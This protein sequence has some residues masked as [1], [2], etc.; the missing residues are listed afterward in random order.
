MLESRH[1]SNEDAF[2][3]KAT[4]CIFCISGLQSVYAMHSLFLL[5]F[6]QFKMDAELGK[7]QDKNKKNNTTLIPPKNVKGASSCLCMEAARTRGCFCDVKD[8]RANGMSCLTRALWSYHS[9]TVHR[10]LLSV[11][12]GIYSNPDVDPRWIQQRA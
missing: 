3:F 2:T 9:A 5:L 7:S 8:C 10:G 4:L 6:S 12:E 11:W 1:V